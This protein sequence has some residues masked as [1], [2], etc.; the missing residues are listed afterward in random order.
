MSTHYAIFYKDQEGKCNGIFCYFNGMLDTTGDI[1]YQNYQNEKLVQQLIDLGGLLFIEEHI[2][3]IVTFKSAL[4]NKMI[5]KK[6]QAEGFYALTDM[7]R[8]KLFY[9]NLA[10]A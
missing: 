10:K 9:Y 5:Y 4:N 2:R 6:K 3:E 8:T 1:L 7:E